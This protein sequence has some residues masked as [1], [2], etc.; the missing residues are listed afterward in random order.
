MCVTVGVAAVWPADLL[1]QRRAVA[2][3]GVHYA[4]FHSSPAFWQR[5]PYPYPYPYPY[6]H[7]HRFDY[8]SSLRFEG[9][10][11]EAE[12]YVNGYFV[13][14]VDDFDGFAQRLHVE[15]GDHEI[16]VYLDGYRTRREQMR[17]RPGRSYRVRFPLE[18]LQ[19]DDPPEPRPMAT[20]PA[21]AAPGDPWGRTHAG[22]RQAAPGALGTLSIRVQPADAVVLIDG[23]RWE[24][25]AGEE[26]L[27]V[28][29]PE[30]TRRIEVRREGHEPY[31][32]TATVRRG[33]VT[34]VNIS[35]P[36]L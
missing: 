1:A 22:A 33:E 4:P 14:I 26:R 11:K 2:V 15:P 21:P 25:P 12:V 3:V 10:P 18:P 36:R 35:L 24:W 30:G 29:V 6:R 20:A 16:A 32:T 8:R 28:D 9:T 31:S 23:E 27:I 19:P 17:L 7:A 34:P 13:G 5:Y